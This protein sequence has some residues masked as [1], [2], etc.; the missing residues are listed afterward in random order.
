MSSQLPVLTKGKYRIALDE[1]W[2]HESYE[3]KSGAIQWYEMI[4]CRGNPIIYLYSENPLTFAYYCTNRRNTLEMLEQ[5]GCRIIS[6]EAEYVALFPLNLLESVCK[7]SRARIKR[8]LSPD[9]IESLAAARN[10]L[11]I[12]RDEKGRL[13]NPS[14]R[15][16]KDSN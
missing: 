14:N 8:T 11:G 5:A 10:K 12:V 3:H 7:L 9:K 6:A 2:E 1:S 13:Y 16:L 15:T 4:L